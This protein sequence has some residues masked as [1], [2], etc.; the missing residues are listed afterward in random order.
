MKARVK[1]KHWRNRGRVW[2]QKLNYKGEACRQD[3]VA[4]DAGD[5]AG[6]DVEENAGRILGRILGRIVGMIAQVG[7]K[8]PCASE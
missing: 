8:P 3:G 4:G 2:G 6:D 5:D 1:D 7:H